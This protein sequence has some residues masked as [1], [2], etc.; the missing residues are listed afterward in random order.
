[1]IKNT[2]WLSS[3][4]MLGE[5]SL[6]GLIIVIFVR[7]IQL[8]ILKTKV[9]FNSY[10]LYDFGLVLVLDLIYLGSFAMILF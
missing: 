3:D 10:F 9:G 4:R 1:M 2:S 5:I 7:T 8:N 6:G